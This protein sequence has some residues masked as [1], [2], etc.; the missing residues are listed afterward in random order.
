MPEDLCTVAERAD[1]V[2]ID[3]AHNFRNTG[4]KGSN[5]EERLSRYWR[6]F[7]LIQ[8]KTVFMLR[9]TPVNQGPEPPEA[10]ASFCTAGLGFFSN[11]LVPVLRHRPQSECDGLPQGWQL[12]LGYYQQT[13][14][15]G[16]NSF[17]TPTFLSPGAIEGSYA[18][19]AAGNQR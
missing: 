6:L 15:E 18:R 19:E 1:V 5:P 7:D 9:S 17:E 14:N 2:I 16:S 12:G 4:A 3:E 8:D 10:S 13:C 11:S